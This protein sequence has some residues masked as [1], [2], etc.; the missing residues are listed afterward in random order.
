M[1]FTPRQVGYRKLIALS[2]LCC[3]G[4]CLTTALAEPDDDFG[5]PQSSIADSNVSPDALSPRVFVRGDLNEDQKVN[6]QDKSLL[7]QFLNSS[8]EGPKCF[9]QADVNDDGEISQKDVSYLE[10]FLKGS[11]P[12]PPHPYDGP[13]S[14]E[15]RGLDLTVNDP[16]T[17][18]DLPATSDP[19]DSRMLHE[20]EM[21][22]AISQDQLEFSGLTREELRKPVYKESIVYSDLGG[23]RALH[24]DAPSMSSFFDPMPR[25]EQSGEQLSYECCVEE[26]EPSPSP[27]PGES[28]TPSPYDYSE[29]EAHNNFQQP[30][31]HLI[32]ELEE[33]PL[34]LASAKAQLSDSAFSEAV[35]TRETSEW[36]ENAD[37]LTTTSS[38]GWVLDQN[39][40]RD[41]DPSEVESPR[42]ETG[43]DVGICPVGRGYDEFFTVMFPGTA[44]AWK[45]D[46]GKDQKTAPGRK[47]SISAGFS[48]LM[49]LTKKRGKTREREC[50]RNR[51]VHWW[52]YSFNSS[53]SGNASTQAEN[54]MDLINKSIPKNGKECTQPKNIYIHLVSFCG[55]VP[56]MLDMLRQLDQKLKKEKGCSCCDDKKSMGCPAEPCPPFPACKGGGEE[57][58]AKVHISWTGIAGVLHGA[59]APKWAPGIPIFGVRLL[60]GVGQANYTPPAKPLCGV[61]SR[62]LYYLIGGVENGNDVKVGSRDPRYPTTYDGNR[63]VSRIPTTAAWRTAL[64]KN[65][66]GVYLGVPTTKP[67][68]K[69]T[70]APLKVFPN[71]YTPWCGCGNWTPG[72]Y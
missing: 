70:D 1:S 55:G 58:I 71:G 39:G 29:P 33:S 17:C 9:D 60:T 59:G 6:E 12:K 52:K 35:L 28:P 49:E 15:P 40:W 25:A 8:W 54:I 67:P 32:T 36:R 24:Y 30:P 63:Y 62:K 37:Y 19:L 23:E 5:L 22:F 13:D 31:P 53:I 14:Y 20:V 26:L 51:G 47:Q 3:L 69:H 10:S 57:H 7:V 66:H 64:Y 48:K 21:S 34:M 18:G 68:P 44:K 43:S 4:C 65:V 38:S 2:I 50:C 16:Y 61:C 56:I 45:D 11:G 42:N 46:Y 72:K 27:S 41:M